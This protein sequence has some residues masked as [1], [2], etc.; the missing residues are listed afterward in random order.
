MRYSI[1]PIDFYHFLN[2]LVQMK[3]KEPKTT[4]DLIV[5]KIAEKITIISISPQNAIKNCIQKEVRIK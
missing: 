5:N 1:E 2:I 3:V 4:A